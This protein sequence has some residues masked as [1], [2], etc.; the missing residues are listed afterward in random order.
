MGVLH[1]KP[2]AKTPRLREGMLEVRIERIDLLIEADLIV[3]LT[4]RARCIIVTTIAGARPSSFCSEAQRPLTERLDI[5]Q[6]GDI[7]VDMLIGQRIE[8]EVRACDR[9]T[10]RGQARGGKATILPTAVADIVHVPR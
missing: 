9:S 10:L 7:G 4:H 5:V 6:A 3:V 2:R 1:T 8:A